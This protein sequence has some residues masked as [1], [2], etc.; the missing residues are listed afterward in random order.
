MESK[1]K[2]KACRREK[3]TRQAIDASDGWDPDM[4]SSIFDFGSESKNTQWNE[5]RRREAT[6]KM[7]YNWQHKKGKLCICRRVYYISHSCLSTLSINGRNWEINVSYYVFVIGVVVHSFF[8]IHRRR[9]CRSIFNLVKVCWFY[10]LIY[11]NCHW[12]YH[13][14]MCFDEIPGW[15]SHLEC[16]FLLLSLFYFVFS[17]WVCVCLFEKEIKFIFEDSFSIWFSVI[18]YCPFF[19]SMTMLFF[20]HCSVLIATYKMVNIIRFY[21]PF[22][23]IIF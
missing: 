10:R 20:V 6:G 2:T 21:W 1:K 15:L 23:I 8:A 3:N 14:P 9:R 22:G 16:F 11:N 5:Y 19:L 7:E 17:L 4:F 12:K 18:F 13:F